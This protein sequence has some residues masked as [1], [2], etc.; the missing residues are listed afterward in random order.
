M[1]ASNHEDARVRPCEVLGT[2]SSYSNC[3]ADYN[4]CVINSILCRGSE[5]VMWVVHPQ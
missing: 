5:F 2:E 3:S 1:G 4:P